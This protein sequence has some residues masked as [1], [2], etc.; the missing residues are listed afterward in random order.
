MEPISH[1]KR[2]ASESEASE[3]LAL[4]SGQQITRIPP[5]LPYLTTQQ[6]FLDYQAK[7]GNR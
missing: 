7:V 2:R 3:A 5:P 1:N 6:F 4:I